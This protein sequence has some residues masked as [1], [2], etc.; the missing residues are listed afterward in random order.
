M[1]SGPAAT[2]GR[3]RALQRPR[4]PRR[5]AAGRARTRTCGG[6]R[7]DRRAV[8]HGVPGAR[9]R[10]IA[11]AIALD[12]EYRHELSPP[13][14]SARAA[15]GRNCR[16]ERVPGSAFAPR[17]VPAALHSAYPPPAHSCCGVLHRRAPAVTAALSC[18]ATRCVAITVSQVP[19][20]SY[21]VSSTR[22]RAC[23]ERDQLAAVVRDQQFQFDIG[24]RQRRRDRARA[25]HRR[26][27]R[28]GR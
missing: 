13:Q 26:P 22:A 7:D 12:P 18:S 17:P 20:S 15:R 8:R 4:P 19:R 6:R 27:R 21:R 25:A 5:C 23:G 28:F 11:G 14:P 3:Q 16:L 24:M 9:A 2:S 10:R 1:N